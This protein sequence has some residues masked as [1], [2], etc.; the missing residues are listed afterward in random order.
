MKEKS[1]Q[2]FEK[3][4]E[5]GKLIKEIGPGKLA[6]ILLCGVALILLSM[7]GLF[8]KDKE[9]EDKMPAVQTGT[10]DSF[11]SYGEKM[12]KKFEEVLGQ[13]QGIGEV[14][15]M[16]TLKSSEEQVVLKD[17]PYSEETVTEQDSGGGSRVS[18]SISREEA[19]VLSEGPYVVKTIQ[20]E[21][22][23]IVVI[24]QGGGDPVTVTQIVEAAEALFNVPAHKIKVMKKK[25]G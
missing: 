7:P 20:P 25:N 12:E 22:Q 18:S 10:Q 11:S 8:S 23:G 4:K 16:I 24:A 9:E 14:D 2:V 1:E 13:V 5:K 21:I 17:E 3:L 15:V 6:I 19:T